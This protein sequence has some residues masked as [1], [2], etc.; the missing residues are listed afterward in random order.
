M[1]RALLSLALLLVASCDGGTPA[2]P[3]PRRSAAG[4]AGASASAALPTPE[5]V[6]VPEG[7][8]NGRAWVQGEMARAERDG[9]TLVLY[10]GAS[11]CEPCQR[12][13]Q[14]LEKGELDREL[15]GVRFLDFDH[16]RHEGLL[17]SADLA[18]GAQLI[19][20]FA[21]LEPNGTCSAQRRSEGGIKGDGAVGFMLPKIK[22]IL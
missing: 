15:G 22:A 21:R 14:A 1:D 4:S 13:H 10:V 17:D 20:L 18:C 5:L 19:P 11:W 8:T 3:E 7:V 6:A 9:R 12:F 2:E 16:D